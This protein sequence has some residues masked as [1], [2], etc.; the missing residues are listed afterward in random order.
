MILVDANLL[1]YAVNA[2][3]P[4][5]RKARQWLE[6][7]LSGTEDVGLPWLVVLAFLRITTRQGIL[8]RPLT[9]EQALEYV[10]GWLAQ[11]FV[12]LVGPGASH[13]PVFRNLLCA[14]G[15]FGNLCSDAHLAALAIELGANI[16]SADY[17]FRRF[18]GVAHTNPLE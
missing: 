1:I 16:H 11:P 8:E 10:D 15:T 2:D 13:W 18:P 17:D 7:T 5:H 6:R 12:S 14:T 9:T 4:Q 3:A